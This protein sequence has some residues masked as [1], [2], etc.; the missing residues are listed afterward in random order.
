ML[1]CVHSRKHP[2]MHDN[3]LAAASERFSFGFADW[4]GVFGT[5]NLAQADKRLWLQCLCGLEGPTCPII[6]D[7]AFSD[8]LRA[9]PPPAAPDQGDE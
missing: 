4:R 3:E 5:S 8:G 9:E 1:I 6:P 2:I 7:D